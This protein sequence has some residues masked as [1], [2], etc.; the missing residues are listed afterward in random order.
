MLSAKNKDSF[1]PAIQKGSYLTCLDVSRKHG[2]KADYLFIPPPLDLSLLP[3][4]GQQVVSERWSL[5]FKKI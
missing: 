1:L 2:S 3:S 5:N 4:V